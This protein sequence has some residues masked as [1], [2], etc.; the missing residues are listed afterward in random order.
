M[1]EFDLGEIDGTYAMA[2]V[3][4]SMPSSCCD[5][6]KSVGNASGVGN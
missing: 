1:L 6:E 4:A 5:G 3:V 2:Y